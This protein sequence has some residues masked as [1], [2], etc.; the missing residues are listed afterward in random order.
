MSDILKNEN[1]DI[2][3]IEEDF[4]ENEEV[5]DEDFCDKEELIENKTEYRPAK[6][7]SERIENFYKE[8]KEGNKKLGVT[9]LSCLV[10]F[11]AGVCGGVVGS[12]AMYTSLTEQIKP[13]TTIQQNTINLT[14]M[15]DYYSVSK[16]V[17]NVMPSVVAITNYSTQTIQYMF[18]VGEYEMES[19]GSGVIIGK[20]DKELLIVTNYHVIENSNELYVNFSTEDTQDINPLDSSQNKTGV[21]ANVKGTDYESDIAII[22]IRL[23]DIDSE[24]LSQLAIA[25]FG[26]STKLDVGDEVIAIGNA[27][28]YG[29]SVTTGV[30]SALNKSIDVD[31]TMY[32]NLIQTD[33]AINPGNSGGAL[34]N[35]EGKLIGINSAKMA[36]N[37]VEGMG[38]AISISSITDILDELSA[39]ETKEK[40]K[41]E[42][43]GYLGISGYDVDEFSAQRY[44]LPQGVYIADISRQSSLNDS[45]VKV[46][47][48]ITKF[49]GKEINTMVELQGMLAYY[50]AG[51]K[52]IL[53]IQRSDNGEYIEKEIQVKLGGNQILNDLE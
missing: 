6:I 26:D 7:E 4:I 41:E 44:N 40:V 11:A 36:A 46:G 50:S 14:E 42:N 12:M 33:A 20:N 30:V 8:R 28:G 19:A 43:R 1:N 38:Y 5:T 49:D 25:T 47:D 13:Q 22:S 23:S 21:I 9:V 53:T 3:V 32:E 18:D 24:T 16:I 15:D 52:V 27:C 35:K 17:S 37:G 2:E 29:Q 48:I 31:G 34:F 45:D 51:E 39:L 10:A